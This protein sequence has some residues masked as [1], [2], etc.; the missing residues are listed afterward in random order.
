VVNL[1]DGG[2]DDTVLSAADPAQRPMIHLST[3][4]G[5]VHALKLQS[6]SVSDIDVR[7]V[8]SA[9]M[10][11]GVFAS[12]IDRVSVVGPASV[13]ACTGRTVSN[14][15][16]ASSFAGAS[17][18]SFAISAGGPISLELNL[19]NVTAWGGG[20]GGSGVA[21]NA[22]S[23]VA[24]TAFLHNSIIHGEDKDISLLNSG[25]AGTTLAAEARHTNF[26]TQQLTGANVT[27][28][29]PPGGAN[30]SNAPQLVNPAG[31]DFR[32]LAGSTTID[33]GDDAFTAGTA[34]VAG[35]PRGQGAHIDIGAHEFS[36]PSPPVN[37]S[38]VLTQFR[39]R[40]SHFRRVR[41]DDVHH[42]EVRAGRPHPNR[43]EKP[44]GVQFSFTLSRADSV[45]FS[46]DRA[47]SGRRAGTRCV[48]RTRGNVSRKRCTYYRRLTGE[49]TVAGTVGRNTLWWTGRWRGRD[50]SVKSSGYVLKALAIGAAAGTAP[51]QIS[52]RPLHPSA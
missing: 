50:L 11:Y 51:I 10:M 14:S 46:L 36:P 3:I 26:S 49:E 4:V 1:A 27:L 2:R 35:S 38:T 33:A 15:V 7:L 39:A 41:S 45:R 30:Q 8:S 52:P 32:E 43:G 12:S 48:K 37:P 6:G 22:G 18:F 29:S 9:T 40:K 16:C 28:S 25:G 17:G 44:G 19:T 34:D 42:N 21:I 13:S 23:N 47:Y 31:G 24:I 5:V 20:T